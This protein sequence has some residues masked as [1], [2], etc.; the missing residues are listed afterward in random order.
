MDMEDGAW[1][2]TLVS[3][4]AKGRGS[5]WKDGKRKRSSST[6]LS[7]EYWSGYYSWIGVGTEHG[8]EDIIPSNEERLLKRAPRRRRRRR[9][10]R[11]PPYCRSTLPVGMMLAWKS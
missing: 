8:K 1:S 11:D 9:R 3:G 2:P 7:R 10:R 4:F 6:V 5:R